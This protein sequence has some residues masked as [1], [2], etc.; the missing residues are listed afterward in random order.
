MKYKTNKGMPG[1]KKWFL[2]ITKKILSEFKGS[3]YEEKG[4][5]LIKSKINLTIK[6]IKEAEEIIA[7]FNKPN[8][9][10]K[11]SKTSHLL[12]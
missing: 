2:S 9:D 12:K 11:D 4:I 10:T 1:Q 7:E 8:L 6:S 3:L 5:D